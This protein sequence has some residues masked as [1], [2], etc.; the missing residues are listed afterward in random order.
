MYTKF[1]TAIL[2]L[3]L[4]CSTAHGNNLDV[5]G[6]LTIAGSLTLGNDPNYSP[7]LIPA[8]VAGRGPAIMEMGTDSNPIMMFG[9][10]QRPYYRL[11]LANE[12]GLSWVISPDLVLPDANPKM[13]A[14]LQYIGE[15]GTEDSVIRPFMT[16]IDKVT[17]LPTETSI[18]GGSSLS[19]RLIDGTGTTAEKQ[20]GKVRLAIDPTK[21]AVSGELDAEYL[22]ATA[23]TSDTD[24]VAFPLLLSHLS[25]GTPTRGFGTGISL[26]AQQVGSAGMQEYAQIKASGLTF[27]TG[28]LTFSSLYGNGNMVDAMT[29][30]AGKVGIGTT[31]P[32]DK[33]EVNGYVNA[34]SGFKCGGVAPV[35]D[36]T[37]VIGSR[38]TPNGH[39]GT[40]TLKGGIIVAIQEAN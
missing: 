4:F 19:L 8:T 17:H 5:D 16:Q 6:S 39:D 12:P 7:L 37:Y 40:I 23:T 11:G 22:N 14:Y 33:L 9:Y 34:Y 15:D 35:A 20:V 26:R 38:L 18:S 27:N 25:T 36:G 28:S 1:L 30:W 32:K 10:N 3:T 21:V 31:A 24:T 13:E 29:I 2:I